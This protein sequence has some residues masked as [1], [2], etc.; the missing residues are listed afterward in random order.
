MDW[1][2]WSVLHPDRDLKEKLLIL[3]LL[4]PIAVPIIIGS[5]YVIYLRMKRRIMKVNIVIVCN[6]DD[7]LIY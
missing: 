5:C 7:K 3:L 6:G 1:A 2:K 4:G